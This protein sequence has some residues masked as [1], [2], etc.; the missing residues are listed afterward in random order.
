MFRHCD[1]QRM[2]PA[3]GLVLVTSLATTAVN[4][5]FS[6][7]VSH[8][9]VAQ[10]L[11]DAQE[12]QLTQ[13]AEQIVDLLNQKNYARVREL[14]APQ[15]A[16]QLTTEQVAQIWENLIAKTGPVQKILS[17]RVINTVNADLVVV[18]AEFAQEKSDFIITFNRDRQIVGVDFPKVESIEEIAEIFVNSIVENNYPRARGYLH[19]FLKTE[20]FPQQIQG[21]WQAI[22]KQNGAFQRIVETDVRSGSTVD[23]TDVAI[24]TVEFSKT[25]EPVFIMFNS[26]RQIVGIDLPD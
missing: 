18:T 12:K 9:E 17:Y 16:S 20:I 6:P 11:T 5:Q 23:D 1:R 3:L 2:I 22:V 21:T 15:L 19:P 24:V 25:T 26:Q 8:L 14:L 7:L 13:K 4:A 10:S